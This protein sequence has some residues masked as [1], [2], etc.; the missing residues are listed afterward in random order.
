M[1]HTFDQHA[2]PA[3]IVKPEE[4]FASGI[5]DCD[6]DEDSPS[7]EVSDHSLTKFYHFYAD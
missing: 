4:N 5:P 3:S 2:D 6:F 1:Q 7:A